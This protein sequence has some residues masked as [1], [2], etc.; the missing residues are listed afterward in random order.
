MTIALK[1]VLETALTLLGPQP[2]FGDKVLKVRVLR[3]H[4]WE[5]GAKRVNAR[6]SDS[7]IN[8][9]FDNV[10]VITTLV[11]TTMITL[12]IV[13]ATTLALTTTLT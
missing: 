7:A 12:S 1:L 5:C 3:P 9:F 6:A 4:I 2:R 10:I 8:S 11:L 13:T